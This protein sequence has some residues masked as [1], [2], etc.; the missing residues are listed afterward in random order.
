[1]T[2]NSPSNSPA[3]YALTARGLELALRLRAALGGV[4]FAPEAL[5][6]GVADVRGFASLPELAAAEFNNFR[7]HIFISAA[8]IAVR[9]IAPLIADKTVDPAVLVLDQRGAFVVSLLSGHLGGANAL[10]E[11]VAALVGGTAVIT[12]ATDTE[13]L[14]AADLLAAREGLR[15]GNPEAIRAVNAA[16][17][18][19]ERVGLYDPEAWLRG[20]MSAEELQHFELLA[21]AEALDDFLAKTPQGAVVR[22]SWEK[23]EASEA[24][25]CLIPPALC[26]GVGCRRGAG[27]EEV[28]ALVR[29]ACAAEG[30]DAR[31]AACLASAEIK[32]DEPGLVAAARE[33]GVALRVFAAEELALYPPVEVSVK[34]LEAVGLPGVCEPAARAAAG[35]GP[36][37]AGK[38]IKGPVTLAVALAAS[39]KGAAES[40][41]IL[42]AAPEAVGKLY[43]CGLGPG[44]AALLTPQAEAALRKSDE[45][46]GYATYVDLLPPDILAGKTVHR[47]RM[48]G[49]V[50]RCAEA[51]RA[52]AAGRRV[53]LVSS[54]DAGIYGMAGLV[55]ELAETFAREDE[56]YL[57][58]EVEII[59]GVPA[60]C[61][62]AARL[63]A[64]LMHDFAVISLSDLLTP[65]ELIE[66]RV[67]AAAEADFV[68]VL[69]NPSSRGRGE[70]FARI[71][72]LLRDLCGDD[73]PCG[74]AREVFRPGERVSAGRLSELN[75]DEVDMLSL[76]LVGNS[77]TRISGGRLITPRGYLSKYRA[78]RAF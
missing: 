66:K 62:A 9:C 56:T 5:A 76:V 23:I 14:P 2:T 19:G 57:P 41:D 28:L 17:L 49:E 27:A 4:C 50:E 67:Q 15:I 7:Q 13:G 29:G 8:G 77:Q 70:K 60:L 30:W 63:G 10:A 43:V 33:L 6:G 72:A 34:A 48:G 40:G 52:A 75:P 69:Y 37:L 26:F 51:L 54:G 53:S 36:L 61:A 18:A 12:T 32:A 46:F 47:G 73:R 1:M 64:P 24:C 39:G 3:I 68:L 45:I 74:L 59:P 42:A 55:L 78:E 58:P 44:D 21:D 65:W 38:M 35:G 16:L 20:G 11:R 31:A 25:L 71:W 22:V